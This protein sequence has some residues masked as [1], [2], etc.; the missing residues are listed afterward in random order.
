[1]SLAEELR[2]YIITL[3]H[4]RRIAEFKEQYKKANSGKEP[5]QKNINDFIALMIAS[6]TL[7]QEAKEIAEA[8]IRKAKWHARPRHLLFY[9][10]YTIPLLSLLGLLILV[11]WFGVIPDFLLSGAGYYTTLTTA[12]ILFMVVLIGTVITALREK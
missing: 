2:P 3:L 4:E 10:A 8:F 5:S 9:S 12:F 1:M 11:I 6:G 7:D